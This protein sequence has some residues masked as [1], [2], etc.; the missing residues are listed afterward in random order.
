MR[1]GRLAVARKAVGDLGEALIWLSQAGSGRAAENKLSAL[2]RAL[3][4]VSEAPERW[5]YFDKARS[6]RMKASTGGYLIVYAIHEGDG[7][8]DDGCHI[9][10]LH[11]LGPGQRRT[12]PGSKR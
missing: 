4:A 6:M 9:E 2:R 1:I 8:A 7:S 12:S 10:I 5:P 3:Q 11:V